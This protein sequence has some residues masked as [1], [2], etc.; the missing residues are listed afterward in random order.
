MKSVGSLSMVS[1][2]VSALS[3]AILATTSIVPATAR[4][5]ESAEAI[6]PGLGVKRVS[7][8]P[9]GDWIAAIAHRGKEESV[10]V[11][12]IGL[13]NL[14]DVVTEKEIIRISWDASG[15][16]IVE[17][18][19]A[20]DR[21]SVTVIGLSVSGDRIVPRHR[22]IA[23]K[24]RLIDALPLVPEKLLWLTF[25]REFTT[26]HR[27]SI[28][29]LVDF[30]RLHKVM[31]G[32]FHIGERVAL[33]KGH[34]SDHWVVQ[35]DG[36]PRA[37][38]RYMED[39]IGLMISPDGRNKVNTAYRWKA[40]E[41]EH[42]VIPVGLTPDERTILVL[43]YR[44]DGTRGLYE[45]DVKKS[46]PGKPVFVH[47][48]YDLSGVLSDP[49]TGDLV[50]AV[51]EDAGEQRFHYF[52]EY[53]ARYLSRLPEDWR[54]E[55]VAIL[56]GSADR[57]VFALLDASATNPG[58]FYV[59]DRVGRVHRVGRI[60]EN[61]DRAKLSPV[62]SFR[63]KSKDGVEV[64][65]FLAPPKDA[66]GRAPLVV[67]PH[68]GPI[69]V[70]DSR[71]FDPLVQYLTSW[72]FAVVQVN[73]RGSSGYGLEFEKQGAKQWARGIE[74]DIDA[75]VE[76]AMAD[77]RIDPERIC[78]F[79][80]SYGGFSAFASV[81]RHRERY[82]C[83]VS[84][85]GVSD[86]PLFG[87]T[88]DFA[89]SKQV[90]KEFE[91]K[92]GDLET[93]RDKLLEVSPAYHVDALSVPTLIIQ[94]LDDRRVDPDHAHRMA[95]MFELYDKPFELLEIEGGEHSPDRDEWIIIARTLRRFLTAH[96]MQ[97]TGFAPDPP[98]RWDR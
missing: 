28:D 17:A 85:N 23:A 69:G 60:A 96:L 59:R 89:D 66:R 90:M 35:R 22:R 45:W 68:G 56:G 80:V 14:A 13:P 47:P 55:S 75:A 30:A 15:T 61:V 1:M 97:E 41:R 31:G 25:G 24:G 53:R 76:Q 91:E 26:V 50:A 32:D 57:Q 81:I 6:W 10:V 8:D 16:L 33:A 49:L 62:E 18:V 84:V 37:A 73:Y 19:T 27:L 38:L 87:E 86:I 77:P 48:E 54:R 46:A 72:G 7:V 34:H 40:G 67:M 44:G 63:A 94:G 71:H 9:S 58:D 83:A 2:L 12:R 11:Q 51:Y 78:I 52:D 3:L 93:E 29:E 20:A 43:A 42:E 65:G 92:I 5:G 82:R 21:Y 74:D 39:F 88:A 4:A 98:T 79:G 95:L 36:T 70:H 64:E